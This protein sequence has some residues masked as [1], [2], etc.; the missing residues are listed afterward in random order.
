MPYVVGR[1]PHLHSPLAGRSPRGDAEHS[2]VEIVD[3]D[4]EI[5]RRRARS[6][7]P[8]GVDPAY[9][10]SAAELKQT[11]SVSIDLSLNL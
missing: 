8:R 10:D 6:P 11:A 1:H 4:G 5:G 2:P 7:Y 9:F 3:Q